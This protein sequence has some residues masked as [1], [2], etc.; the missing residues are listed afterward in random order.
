M[1]SSQDGYRDNPFLVSNWPITQHVCGDSGPDCT[2]PSVFYSESKDVRT[3]EEQQMEPA[4]VTRK[5]MIRSRKECTAEAIK[6]TQKTDVL[7]K[8]PTKNDICDQNFVNYKLIKDK[9]LL[10]F[11]LSGLFL[12]RWTD[13]RGSICH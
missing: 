4:V 5:T 12:F 2:R 13:F 6:G 3:S 9:F 10:P 1:T 8:V 11:H 7:S